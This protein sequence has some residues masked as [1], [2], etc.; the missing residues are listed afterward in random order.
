MFYIRSIRP[1]TIIPRLTPSLKRTVT[2]EPSKPFPPPQPTR[3]VDMLDQKKDDKKIAMSPT[4]D[5]VAEDMSH[6][7]NVSFRQSHHFDTY[8]LLT[9][10]EGQG[11][12]RKQAEVIMKGIK[13]RLREW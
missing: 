6:K 5:A 10:L 11:F 7:K 9:Q 4:L 8:K 12:S 1:K 3:P 2:Y 13:F